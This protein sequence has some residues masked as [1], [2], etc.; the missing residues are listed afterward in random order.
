DVLPP[1]ANLTVRTI[2][3]V[4]ANPAAPPNQPI[5]ITGTAPSGGVS[6]QQQAV[7]IDASS[8]PSGTVIQLQNVDFAAVVGAVR[9][10][11]GEGSQVVAGDSADQWMVLGA[12]DDTLRGGGGN[13]FV[14]SEGG[15]DVL[16]GDTGL[17]TVTGGIGNDALYGNQQDDVVYGN[18][19]LDTLFGGQDAD[20][21]FGGQD[22]D[23]LYGNRAADVLY[24]QLG[25]DTLFGGQDNDV[26]FGGQGDDLLAGNLGADTLTGGLG[27]D[28]FRIGSPLEGGD[29]IADFTLGEDRIGVVGPNFGNIPAGTL[30]ASHFALD[31][32]T[33]A[34]ATFVFNTRT[35]A[36]SFDADGSGAGAAVTIATL[37]VRTLSH[38]DILVLGGGS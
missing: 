24:G 14:G 13:D 30:S 12:D 22:G 37:N 27:A 1:T 29:M 19:G 26:L 5:I 17:D 7:V 21:V 23:V 34:G 36:L 18:Q 9:V 20:T 6:T 2:I 25:S 10:T 31:N 32:P 35:G 4:V 38:T 28:T 16:Y 15:D 3:P 8:L 11:G 33:S